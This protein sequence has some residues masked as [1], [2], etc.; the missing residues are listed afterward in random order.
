MKKGIEQEA[1]Q[2][3]KEHR[4]LL[5]STYLDSC[6]PIDEKIAY[7]T[8]G[9]SG[10]GKT[11]FIQKFIQTEKNLV[12][13]DID[14]IRD[15]FIPLGYDGKNSDMFQK[16]ASYGV[17][18]LFDEIIKVKGLSLIVDSNLSHFQTAKENMVK[19]LNQNYKVEI[20]YIYND[21]EKCFL[22]TKKRESVTNRV[23]P[24]DVFFKSVIKSRSTTSEIK[25]LF[26]DKIILN[27]V[28]KRDNKYYQDIN[29]NEFEKIIPEYKAKK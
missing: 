1:I 8:A 25:Q 2:Y 28:D 12:H 3:L 10:A 20:F 5:Y 4:E 22:Y 24:E 9:P 13:L 27:V 19:L 6:F 26:S 29:Y 15:F 21:L 11:E 7:F 14:T 17:Q 23:V 18:F 16:P